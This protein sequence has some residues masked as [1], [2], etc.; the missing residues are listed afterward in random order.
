MQKVEI[1]AAECYFANLYYNYHRGSNENANGMI[2]WD[3]PKCIDLA[4]V[5]HT[6]LQ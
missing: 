4:N 5:D 6:E 1:L 3:Y 2:R